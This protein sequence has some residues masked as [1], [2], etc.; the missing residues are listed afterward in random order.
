EVY[1]QDHIPNLLAVPGVLAVSRMKSQPF[2]VTIGGERKKMPAGSPSY[3]AIYELESP[4]VLV[5]EAW[6]QAVEAGRWPGEVRPF[7]TNRRHVLA[8]VI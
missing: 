3:T 1:D 5:S 2:A 8:R 7:T 6:T 4:E